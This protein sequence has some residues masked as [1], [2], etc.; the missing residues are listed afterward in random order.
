MNSDEG[1]I[2]LAVDF[3]H[4]YWTEYSLYVPQC[5]LRRADKL[6]AADRTD[7]DS[8][9]CQHSGDVTFVRLAN[10]PT[11]P[12]VPVMSKTSALATPTAKVIVEESGELISCVF[13]HRM[14]CSDVY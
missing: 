13:E 6:T 12:S 2:G 8:W 5:T 7:L 9:Y 11:A 4:I 10:A 3:S 1:P 14:A